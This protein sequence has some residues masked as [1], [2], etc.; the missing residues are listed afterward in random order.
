MRYIVQ[1]I[2]DSGKSLGLSHAGRFYVEDRRLQRNLDR[3]MADPA[4]TVAALSG[5]IADH[6]V[7]ETLVKTDDLVRTTILQLEA[8]LGRKLGRERAQKL[9]A[10]YTRIRAARLRKSARSAKSKKTPQHLAA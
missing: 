4:L 7:V 10:A 9:L 6:R 8:K 1:Q 5:V 3:V 2:V